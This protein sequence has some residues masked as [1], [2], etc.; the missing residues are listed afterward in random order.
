MVKEIFLLFA[1]HFLQLFYFYT[2]IHHLLW[3]IIS[4][5]VLARSEEVVTCQ[6]PVMKTKHHQTVKE[7]IKASY[8]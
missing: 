1:H 2:K 3:N 7:Q 5:Q 6:W 8:T 4:R